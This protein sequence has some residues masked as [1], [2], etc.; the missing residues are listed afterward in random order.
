M[1]GEALYDS[2]V[3]DIVQLFELIDRA[4]L[5]GLSGLAWLDQYIYIN[6]QSPCCCLAHLVVPDGEEIVETI[7]R[8]RL[9]GR[10]GAVP[11]GLQTL[12]VWKIS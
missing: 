3:G 11:G 2:L 6:Y 10:S 8:E 4:G 7:M 5:T 9:D 12:L 1:M